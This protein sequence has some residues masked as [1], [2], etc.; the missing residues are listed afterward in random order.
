MSL[1]HR[2]VH[3]FPLPERVYASSHE[4]GFKFH[5]CT[6]TA[7]AEAHLGY[8]KNDWKVEFRRFWIFLLGSKKVARNKGQGN[9]SITF[10][11]TEHEMNAESPSNF[12]YPS[13]HFL[14]VVLKTGRNYQKIIA[15]CEQY[16][17]KKVS[18][19]KALGEFVMNHSKCPESY[20]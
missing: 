14:I 11:Y 20:F 13:N 2:G 18:I 12:S 17:F 1:G 15:I 9:F 10:W 8:P 6:T 5:H 16:N 7:I 3:H 4:I 19:C